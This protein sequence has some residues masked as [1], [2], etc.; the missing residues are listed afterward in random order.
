MLFKGKKVT[1]Q[2]TKSRNFRGSLLE[3]GVSGIRKSS[4]LL[5]FYLEH[6]SNKNCRLKYNK[7][8][9]YQALV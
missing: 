8:S 3:V 6:S 5:K 2:R 4:L 1:A 7:I 9:A